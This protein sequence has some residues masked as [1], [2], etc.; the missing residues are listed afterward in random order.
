MNAENEAD[1]HFGAGAL[2]HFSWKDMLDLYTC[3]ECGRCQTHCPAYNTGKPLSP[4]TLI[5]DLRDL[6][7]ENLAGGYAAH[8]AR[9]ARGRG[10]WSRSGGQRRRDVDERRSSSRERCTIV[11]GTLPAVVAL[12]RR[13]SAAVGARRRDAPAHRR[14]HPRGDAL[15]VHDVRRV[16]GPVPGAHRARSEDPGHAPPPRARRVAHAEA[17]G[18]RRCAT[19]RTSPTRMGCRISH[20]PTGRRTSDIA[21]VAD[22]PDAEYL[23]WVGCAASFDERAQ[24][25]RRRTVE[26]PQGGRASTSPSSAPRR[27]A[28][29]TPRD[30]SATSTCSRSARRRTSRC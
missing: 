12:A 17:G 8:E 3:T 1:Q 5:T 23:Y 13:R 28:P 14:H 10:V 19:S 29:A 4:K 16:H 15:V 11:P 18:D 27:S 2:E 20:A 9:R 7:Y 22:K 6:A 26:D 30:G 25:D 24:H 21:F